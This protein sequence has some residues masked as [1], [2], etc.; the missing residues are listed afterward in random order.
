MKHCRVATLWGDGGSVAYG[1]QSKTST[2]KEG[3]PIKYQLW[4]KFIF[5]QSDWRKDDVSTSKPKVETTKKKENVVV[6]NKGKP[7]TQQC[8]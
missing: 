5:M 3:Q 4:V 8:N 1:N 7:K 2:V 6:I